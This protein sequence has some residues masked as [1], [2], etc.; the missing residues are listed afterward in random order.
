MKKILMFIGLN[1]ALATIVQAAQYE[2]KDIMGRLMVMDQAEGAVQGIIEV[3]KSQKNDKAMGPIFV[4]LKLLSFK[5]QQVDMQCSGSFEADLQQ[6]V[7]VC[8]TT[9][10]LAIKLNN[11]NKELVSYL[12]GSFAQA[13]FTLVD[14]PLKE[15]SEKISVDIKNLD[16]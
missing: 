10:V 3:R 1:L 13:E 6:L 15:S 12:Q 14:R 16:L 2:E 11:T 9:K 8:G 5:G 7:V 4:S